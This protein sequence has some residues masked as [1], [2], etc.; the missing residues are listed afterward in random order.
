MLEQRI[1]QLVEGTLDSMGYAIVQIR[2]IDKGQHT[3]QLMAERKSDGDLV[4][5]DCEKISRA[6]SAILDVEDPIASEYNLEVSSP[7]I[8]RP[9]VTLEHFKNYIGFDVKITVNEA[10]RGRK[11]FKGKL[12]QVDNDGAIHII[13]K[14]NN[15][16]ATLDFSN[17]GGAQLVLT[18]ELINFSLQKKKPIQQTA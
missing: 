13:V 5:E 7:G 11:R 2:W 6:V 15:E 16:L 9:L 4:I 14:D 12:K 3:L 1:H 18:D 8:D 17:I 10:M